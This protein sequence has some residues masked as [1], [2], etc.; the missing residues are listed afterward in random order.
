M[1]LVVIGRVKAGKGAGRI[2]ENSDVSREPNRVEA[3]MA[4]M[5]TK[6]RI[7][8]NPN[9]RRGGSASMFGIR[10]SECA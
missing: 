4:K 9:R 1:V 2:W 7:T 8:K 6:K 3:R 10:A 5:Q